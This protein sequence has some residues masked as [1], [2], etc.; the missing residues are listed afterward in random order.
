MTEAH[1]AGLESGRRAFDLRV[2]KFPAPARFS[3]AG[4]ASSTARIA[5]GVM[6]PIRRELQLAVRAEKICEQR[7]ELGVDQPAL[8]VFRLRPRIRK[9]DH[10][11]VQRVRTE[12]AREHE[13]R[14]SL[15]DANIL[16]LRGVD[17]D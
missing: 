5:N 17:I 1:A 10:H 9:E 8:V 2:A 3:R 14:V 16:E 7:R 12:H 13:A 11:A 4:S 6:F 15:D